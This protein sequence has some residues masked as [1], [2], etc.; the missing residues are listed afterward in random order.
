MSGEKLAKIC[1]GSTGARIVLI[2]CL[3]VP[4]TVDGISK[5]AA[6]VDLHAVSQVD[7]Y[8]E[9]ALTDRGLERSE[10]VDD[11]TFVRRVY[12]DIVGRIPTFQELQVF[13]KS[14]V[15][16]KRARLIDELLYSSGYA[17]HFYNYWEDV[18][19]I[20]SRGRRTVMVSYQDWVKESLQ[21]N[22]PYDAFVR[23]LVSSSGFVWDEPAV[24]YYLRDAGMP[25]DNM[26]NTAQVFLGTRMQCAQCHDHPFDRWTQKEY[27]HMAAYTFGVDSATRGYRNIPEFKEF[28]RVAREAR[29]TQAS[30]GERV[31]RRLSPAQRRV[32]RDLFEPLG[33]EVTTSSK[34]LKL[35]EDYQYEDGKPNERIVA[36]TPF[37]PEAKAGKRDNLQEVYARWLTSPENP[38]FTKT[39]VNRLW[40][41]VMGVGLIEPVDDL[42]DDTLASHPELLS[43][44]E[45]LMISYE[46]DMKRFLQVVFNTRT[47]QS[48]AYEREPMLGE[49]YYFPGPALRRMTAEQMWDSVLTLSIPDFDKRL[50]GDVQT[51][52]LRVNEAQMKS[53][54]GKVKQLN[55][56][57]LFEI[58]ETLGEMNA[59]YLKSEA[60]F[61]KQINAAETNA[62]KRRLRSELRK[63][64]QE[65]NKKMDSLIASMAGVQAFDRREAM[66][67]IESGMF[68]GAAVARD[69]Q[70]RQLERSRRNLV[71]ASEIV[72]PAPA[73]HFLRQF[74]ESDREIIESSSDE[75]AIP[76]ALAL[77]NG[78]L[79]NTI[80][81]RNSVLSQ[82]LE[83]L[84]GRQRI[85]VLF[86]SFFARPPSA[87][88][89][90]LVREQFNEFGYSKG[91]RN[92]MLALLNSQEFRFVQ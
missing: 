13:E 52:N 72:S 4:L 1:L 83:G 26:S 68:A 11:A 92:V 18:L 54:V 34:P 41:K 6:A 62:E 45:E 16:N 74:G 80:S 64:R 82:E 29:K 91:F 5:T 55:G 44:L 53:H 48:F 75:A 89:R 12:L 73:G 51:R 31:G 35:P 84:E 46:Y 42:K 71:R 56:R 8:I 50:G 47:Y 43:Y 20:Q 38:R 79:L 39:I 87:R 69:K 76:Q 37:G 57:E 30:S 70:S 58:V 59:T 60:A 17:S 90:E 63:V 22:V 3:F 85:E 7:R 66:T 25:L 36:K 78:N 9:E 32:L 40:K 2:L 24:G 77:L 81:N 23:E 19:R 86:K 65:K 14:L 49:P 27:Y 67:E 21:D 28:M 15:P 88:E 10:A 61:Q 33:T